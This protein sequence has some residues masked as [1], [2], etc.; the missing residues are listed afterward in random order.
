MGRHEQREQI[1]K[2]LFRVEYHAE[3][4]MQQQVRLFFEDDEVN[5]SDRDNQY[6][7]EKFDRIREKLKELDHM[8]NE[9]SEGWDTQRIG[10]VELTILRLAAFEILY[11]EQVPAGVAINEAVDIAKKYGQENSGGFVNAILAKFV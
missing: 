4:E 2:L 6:I 5:V 11:D 10:K 3:E 8:I 7:T 1:F 9:K